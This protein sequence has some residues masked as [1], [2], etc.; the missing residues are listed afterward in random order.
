MP[1]RYCVKCGAKVTRQRF[2]RTT[3][4]QTRCRPCIAKDTA[5]T[6]KRR[7]FSGPKNPQWKGGEM[8]SGGYTYLL[9]PSHPRAS[10]KGYVKRAD[11]VLEEK[12]GRA[13]LP[14]E[15]AHHE[16]EDKGNDS[17]AN[18]TPKTRPEHQAL[19]TARRKAAG[20]YANNGKRHDASGKFTSKM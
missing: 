20:K 12:L 17:P 1:T 19:H 5:K 18:L 11:L 13:L 14:N 3:P 8:R 2:R 9:V 15:I 10:K 6:R 16:D 7:D 4:E